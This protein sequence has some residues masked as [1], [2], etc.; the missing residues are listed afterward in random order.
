METL[1]TASVAMD[2]HTDTHTH[3]MLL[4]DF[5]YTLCTEIKANKQLS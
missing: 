5:S 2:G 4:Y 1:V 3:L